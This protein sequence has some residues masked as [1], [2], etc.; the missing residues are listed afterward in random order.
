MSNNR[1]GDCCAHPRVYRVFH[2]RCRTLAFISTGNLNSGSDP[3]SYCFSQNAHFSFLTT[4][5]KQSRVDGQ[6]QCQ[7]T[8]ILGHCGRID[9]TRR[10]SRRCTACADPLG[11]AESVAPVVAAQLLKSQASEP[12]TATSRA[13]SLVLRA[14][15]LC[16]ARLFSATSLGNSKSSA[17]PATKGGTFI[18]RNRPLN[19]R[20]LQSRPSCPSWTAIER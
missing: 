1:P 15:H 14:G 20:T 6:L 12:R 4:R 3:I 17:L 8:R 16:S 9:A 5:A 19:A 10:L 11:K 7:S 13:H 18:S 2:R